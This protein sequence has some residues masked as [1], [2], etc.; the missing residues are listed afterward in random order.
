MCD[1]YGNKIKLTDLEDHNFTVDFVPG[2][3]SNDMPS[4]LLRKSWRSVVRYKLIDIMEK[5]NLTSK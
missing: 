2:S 5:C 1:I 3:I 4:V